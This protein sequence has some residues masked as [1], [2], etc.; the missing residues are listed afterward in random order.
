M[1]YELT[2]EE[3]LESPVKEDKIKSDILT[4]NMGPQHPS[5]HGV[6]RVEIKTDSEIVTE[7][8]PHIGYL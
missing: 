5:T 4:V 3:K 1:S 8:I 7:A 6:L 2:P